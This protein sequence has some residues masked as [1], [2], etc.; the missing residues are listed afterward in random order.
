MHHNL[1]YEKSTNP[2]KWQF[3]SFKIDSKMEH[4]TTLIN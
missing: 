3:T 2:N 1:E 4:Y